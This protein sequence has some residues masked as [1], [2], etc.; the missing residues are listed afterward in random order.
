MATGHITHIDIPSEDIARARRFYS[1]LFGWQI[2]GVE[3]FPDYEMFATGQE[4]VGGGIG[5]RGKT[6]PAG[7]IRV[8][9]TVDSIDQALAKVPGL[10]GS[11]VVEKTEVPG[12]GSYAAVSDSEGNELGLWEVGAERG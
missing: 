2:A 6:A 5:L 11:I 12:M 7:G 4:N 10:G 3:A 9:V 8:Y 1:G